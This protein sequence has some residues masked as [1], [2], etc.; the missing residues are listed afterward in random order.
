MAVEGSDA[1]GS[2]IK[3][4]VSGVLISLIIVIVL[5]IVG[6]SAGATFVLLM[7]RRTGFSHARLGDNV[8]IT[9]PMYLGDAVDDGAPVFVHDGDDDKVHFANPV[10]ESMYA[11]SLSP[12]PRLN[13][14]G[15]LD[16]FISDNA[17]MPV[18]CTELE[19]MG[20]SGNNNA[21]NNNNNSNGNN[22]ANNNKMIRPMAPEEKKGLLEHTDHDTNQDLM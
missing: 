13:S 18:S 8:E 6:I 1:D 7:R 14:S 9:N 2:S 16:G 20:G 4:Q 15:S 12:G 11:S 17:R 21:I 19:R 10:Y 3:D 22:A 5:L